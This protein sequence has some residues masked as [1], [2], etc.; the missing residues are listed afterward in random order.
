MTD[1]LP[2]ASEPQLPAQ[3]R[4]FKYPQ[5]H[6]LPQFDRLEDPFSGMPAASSCRCGNRLFDDIDKLAC[7]F[8]RRLFSCLFDFPG[9]LLAELLFSVFKENSRDPHKA[10][11]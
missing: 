6:R 11:H 5:V 7:C 9:D 3:K 8:N 4:F 2:P 10:I 1:T